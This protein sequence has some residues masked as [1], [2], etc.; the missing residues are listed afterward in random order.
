M[1]FFQA[2]LCSIFGDRL[3][4]RNARYVGRA[5]FVPFSDG[6]RVKAEFVTCGTH[7]KYEALR[8][9]AINKAEG[10]VDQTTLNFNDYFQKMNRPNLT[11]ITPHIWIYQG[12]PEWYGSPTYAD[13]ASLADAACEYVG[14]FAPENEFYEDMDED[15]EMGMRL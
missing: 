15:E 3:E 2:Q 6:T 12:K 8:L 14:L 5:C 13:K 9:M 7:Q 10:T 4:F 1:N 11:D